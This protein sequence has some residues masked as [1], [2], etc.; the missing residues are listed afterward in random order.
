MIKMGAILAGIVVVLVIAIGAGTYLRSEREPSWQVY[1][2][3]STRVGD[4]GSNLVGPAWT[5][6]AQPGDAET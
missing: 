5:G 3:T 4:P 6:E 1:S 2:T